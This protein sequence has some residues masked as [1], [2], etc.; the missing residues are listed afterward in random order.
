MACE[1]Q[2]AAL[3]AANL[4]MQTASADVASR[5]AVVSAC[6]NALINA[7]NETYQQA[8][9]ALTAALEQLNQANQVMDAAVNA[10]NAALAAYNLCMN[11]TTPPNPPGP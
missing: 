10:Y 5:T 2:L 1:T 4:S 3:S 11:N 6:Y 9:L 8:Y 7:T